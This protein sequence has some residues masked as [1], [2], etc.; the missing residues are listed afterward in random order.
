LKIFEQASARDL[1]SWFLTRGVGTMGK[2]VESFPQKRESSL[3][4]IYFQVV[5]NT[6]VAPPFLLGVKQGKLN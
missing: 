3:Y 2:S 6:D 4:L 1:V 5:G